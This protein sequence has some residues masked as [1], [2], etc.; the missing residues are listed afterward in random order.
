VKPV[1]KLSVFLR[2][3]EVLLFGFALFMLIPPVSSQEGH[4]YRYLPAAL[5]GSPALTASLFLAGRRG[6]ENW[7]TGV[8]K[9]GFYLLLVY[10]LKERVAIR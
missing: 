10:V 4:L 2:A 3:V 7:V 1:S 9:L 6:A 8:L 5:I